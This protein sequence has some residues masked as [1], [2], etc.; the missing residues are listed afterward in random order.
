MSA[1]LTAA[2]RRTTIVVANLERSLSFYRDRLALHQ[3][4]IAAGVCVVAP[5][6]RVVVPGRPEIHEMMARDPDGMVI[7]LTQC[8]P[9]R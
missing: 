8:G 3:R 7:N 4:M 6:T 2:V 1:N 9:L 5:P